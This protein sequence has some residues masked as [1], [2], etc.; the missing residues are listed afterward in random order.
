VGEGG[1]GGVGTVK[2]AAAAGQVLGGGRERSI[3]SARK[4]TGDREENLVVGKS[5]G[6]I[7]TVGRCARK[8]VH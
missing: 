7:Q 1:G 2:R 5:E 4:N 8:T 6:R 3:R